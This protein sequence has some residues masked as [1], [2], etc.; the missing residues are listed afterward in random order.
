MSYVIKKLY[1][2][3]KTYKFLSSENKELDYLDNL[4]KLNIFI[5][6]NNSGKSLF[7][8]K[9][10]LND[11]LRFFPTDISVR[12]L[13][14]PLESMIVESTV[15]D[16]I[17]DA[18]INLKNYENDNIKELFKDDWEKIQSFPKIN[19]L[20]QNETSCGG[21]IFLHRIQKQKVQRNLSC[22]DVF[23]I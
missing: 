16:F 8:R 14:S 15:L 1:F 9:I 6:Q 2:E 12:L 21:F 3:D 5:G 17:N 20:Q 10:L 23:G 4:S 18:I 22:R 13:N 11:N 7:M 19:S